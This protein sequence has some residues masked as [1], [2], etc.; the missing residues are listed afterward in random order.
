MQREKS[1]WSEKREKAPGFKLGA[2][3]FCGLG[4]FLDCRGELQ[5]LPALLLG[6]PLAHLFLELR[7]NV[8]LN[9]LGHISSDPTT[10]R[11][12]FFLT[13]KRAIT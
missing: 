11:F 2:W 9:H 5:N 7:R 12:D 3:L 8:K 6:H 10:A 1:L 13:A 4:R